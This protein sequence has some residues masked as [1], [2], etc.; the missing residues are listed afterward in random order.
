[1]EGRLW[2]ESEPGRGSTFHFTVRIGAQT[3]APRQR[4]GVDFELLRGLPILIV[5]DNPTNRRILEEVLANWGASP[6]SVAG[7]AAA[8]EALY[9]AQQ[10]SRA[11]PIVLLDAMMPEMDGY[12]VAGRIAADMTL[13]GTRVVLLTSGEMGGDPARREALKIA[14]S[15]LKPIRQSELLELLMRVLSS[16]PGHTVP[17]KTS[18]P[19]RIAAEPAQRSLQILLAEDNVVNQRVVTTMLEKRGHAVTIAGDGCKALEHWRRMP[20]DLVL[21][22]VQMP[23]LDGFEA[24]A[25]IRQAERETGRHTPVVALTAHAMKGDKERC[26]EG[27]FDDYLSKPVRAEHLFALMEDLLTR[28]D[29]PD[30]S[31][32]P[33]SVPSSGRKVFDRSAAAECT[34]GDQT[35]LNEL[36][37]LFLDDCRHRLDEIRAAIR[38]SDRN[39][40]KRAGHTISGAASNFAAPEVMAAARRLEAD[41]AAGAFADCEEH[42]ASLLS[43]LDRFFDTLELPGGKTPPWRAPR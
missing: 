32:G 37:G 18:A 34:G 41:G 17:A 22:D 1:M 25:A 42:L 12:M 20:F 26:L 7:G 30:A 28:Q 14:A 13:D 31:C 43:A 38:A 3:G 6:V 16:H 9:S 4:V 39:A 29:R 21:M 23:E 27:G 24:V 11:F 19:A 5:D 10:A 15:L 2:V 8:L 33:A 36:L 35:L 40:L